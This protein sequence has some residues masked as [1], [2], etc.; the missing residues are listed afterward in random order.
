VLGRDKRRH[1]LSERPSLKRLN[2]LLGLLEVR[3]QI[4]NAVRKLFAWCL[5]RR[6]QLRHDGTLGREIPEGLE[7]DQGFDAAV[8]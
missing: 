4:G 5:E 2:L 8:R 7:A 3:N 1:T 6:G